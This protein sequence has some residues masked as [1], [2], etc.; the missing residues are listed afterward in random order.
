MGKR[1]TSH[2]STGRRYAPT[3]RRYVQLRVESLED[4]CFLSASSISLFSPTGDNPVVIV[5]TPESNGSAVSWIPI[6]ELSTVGFPADSPPVV[7]FDGNHVTITTQGQGTNDGQDAD[8]SSPGADARVSIG[9]A[10]IEFTLPAGSTVPLVVDDS[11]PD[12]TALGSLS[13][14][15]IPGEGPGNAGLGSDFTQPIIN[16]NGIIIVNAD[17]VDPTQSISASNATMIQN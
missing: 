3:D 6:A 8:P 9:Q 12:S 14:A 4:R 15:I 13:D 7:T 5:V 16:G 2:R 17:T 1:R 11:E 10:T